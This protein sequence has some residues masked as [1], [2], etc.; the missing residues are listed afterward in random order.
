M[1]NCDRVE[2]KKR[3]RAPAQSGEA[4]TKI[5]VRPPKWCVGR[6]NNDSGP[7]LNVSEFY[8]LQRTFLEHF[9]NADAS[10]NWQAIHSRHFDWW[11]FPIDDGSRVEFNMNSESDIETLRSDEDWIS[12]YLESVKLVAKAW[13]WDVDACALISDGGFWDKKD[14]RLAKIIR[15]LWLF[16]QSEYFESMQKFATHINDNVYNKR[17]LFYGRICL[18]E[19]LY[20]KLPRR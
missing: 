4:V 17:G 1:K 16:E 8:K 15:S 10:R 3:K 9:R 20:M 12:G 13:G 5:Q 7:H 11:Q 14:V 18:D 19:V 2:T 6:Q